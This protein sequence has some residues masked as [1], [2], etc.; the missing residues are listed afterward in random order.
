[1]H[2]Y[3][4]GI[5]PGVSGAVALV[6]GGEA[7][8]LNFKNSTE[9]DTADY[10]RDHV[11]DV[12]FCFIEKVHSMPKQGVKSVFT[13]GANYGFYIGVLSVLGIPYERVSPIKWQSYLKCRTGGNKNISKQK[14]QELYPHL[15]ITHSN[16]DALLIAYYCKDVKSTN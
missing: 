9:K 16:A 3:Y 11:N 4:L 8:F 14:A 6:S 10:L 2:D 5:D 7:K 12:N 15:K 1:M 13:F